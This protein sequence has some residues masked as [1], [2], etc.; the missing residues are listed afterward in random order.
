MS[1]PTIAVLKEAATLH[2]EWWKKSGN[3]FPASIIARHIRQ[4]I[5]PPTPPA[6]MDNR[7]EPRDP[8]RPLPSLEHLPGCAYDHA[9][10]EE[11]TGSCVPECPVGG[12][13][14]TKRLIK[15]GLMDPV[16]LKMRESPPAETDDQ[17][18]PVKVRVND[19]VDKELP[20][21]LNAIELKILAGFGN[22]RHVMREHSDGPAGD[23]YF[24]DVDLID[25]EEG[26]QFWVL[27]TCT[28][29]MWP[30]TGQTRKPEPP[31]ETGEPYAPGRMS[32][33][34]Q[35]TANP[36]VDQ[37]MMTQIEAL[38]SD[39]EIVKRCEEL[40][41]P[42]EMGEQLDEAGHPISHNNSFA[43][44]LRKTD[45]SQQPSANPQGDEQSMAYRDGKEE[46]QLDSVTRFICEL[47][48]DRKDLRA[49]LDAATKLR[50]QNAKDSLG[51]IKKHMDILKQLADAQQRLPSAYFSD[52]PLA[53]RIEK[54]VE[55]WGKLKLLSE[56]FLADDSHRDG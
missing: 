23:E 28:P 53:E 46:G 14:T 36:Q 15:A 39:P 29:G 10:P 47:F 32:V 6:E 2:G 50:E 16:T 22:N 19:I 4:H 49:Q 25:L 5:S 45:E 13:E 54:L 44:F 3:E 1:D 38:S 20:T 35:P 33:A 7:I 26:D 21:P 12:L 42:S 56:G 52:R 55:E 41:K 37:S 31:A 27:P 43:S 8:H 30:H 11:H 48:E 24:D 17:R 18:K 9:K 34:D 40:N 51:L